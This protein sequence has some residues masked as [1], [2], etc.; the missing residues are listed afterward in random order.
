MQR[1]AVVER[2]IKNNAYPKN[3]IKEREIVEKG[4][5]NQQKFLRQGKGEEVQGEKRD[6]KI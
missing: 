4:K 6:K 1:H 3:H 5:Q 2:L